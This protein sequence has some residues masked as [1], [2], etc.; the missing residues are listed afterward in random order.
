L[1]FPLPVDLLLSIPWFIF[2]SLPGELPLHAPFELLR[3]SRRI[4]QH[5][6]WD[7]VVDRFPPLILRVGI[8]ENG[9]LFQEEC[10]EVMQT[11]ENGRVW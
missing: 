6:A 1:R 2:R 11:V 7:L 4:A 8:F 10:C 3:Q 5:V 9:D